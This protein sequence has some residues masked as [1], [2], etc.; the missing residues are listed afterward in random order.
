MTRWISAIFLVF[1]LVSGC[2][3]L[4]ENVGTSGR[5]KARLT[6][7][8]LGR[9]VRLIAELTDQRTKQEAL[10]IKVHQYVEE[11][12]PEAVLPRVLASGR[13]SMN[14][15]QYDNS[16]CRL[17]AGVLEVI[18]ILRDQ[19]RLLDKV[20]ESAMQQNSEGRTKDR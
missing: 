20:I 1:C 11:K 18:A 2:Q 10:A 5:P 7:Q 9:A 15:Q 6:D 17:D 13:F 3:S 4:P 12:D 14:S 8:E 19:N 16:C